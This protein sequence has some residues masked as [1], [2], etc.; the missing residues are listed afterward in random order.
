M[1]RVAGR[2][3]HYMGANMVHSQFAALE[4]PG[5]NETDV[6]SVDVSG[7][8]EHVEEEALAKIRQAVQRA[9][10]RDL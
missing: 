8:I 1:K 10:V 2:H 4:K 5:A 7:S 9:L 6:I 3:G